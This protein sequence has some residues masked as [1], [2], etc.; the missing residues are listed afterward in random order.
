MKTIKISSLISVILAFILGAVTFFVINNFLIDEKIE[1]NTFGLIGFVLSIIFG[2]A[3]IILAITAIFLGK[4]SEKIM[5]ERSEKSIELQNDVYIKTTEALKK[6]ESSTGVTEKRIE[7]IISG[8]VGAIADK[9]VEDKIIPDKK[10]KELENELIRSIKTGES[11]EEKR[12]RHEKLKEKADFLKIYEKY[13]EKTLLAITNMDGVKTRKFGEGSI[14]KSGEDLVDGYY[15]YNGIRFGICVFYNHWF[16]EDTLLNDLNNFLNN[17]AKEISNNTFQKIF[18]VFNEGCEITS[19]LEVELSKIRM[20]YKDE[21]I[22]NILV[23]IDDSEHIA[24]KV[25]NQL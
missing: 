21:I 6:I 12:K 19:K 11:E 2:G 18:L 24:E 4:S 20:L 23:I 22:N 13:Q 1:F 16:Y 14:S 3:S 10:R 7:D 25:I 8:R 9:L 15:E 17:I 5:I